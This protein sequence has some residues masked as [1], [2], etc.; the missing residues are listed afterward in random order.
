MVYQH[1][2]VRLCGVGCA[3]PG[4]KDRFERTSPVAIHPA[5]NPDGGNGTGYPCYRA[6]V[7]G[8]LPTV[9]VQ[10]FFRW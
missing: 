7:R 1:N 3:V 6:A 8:T 2:G 5:N 9:L 4:F 10:P